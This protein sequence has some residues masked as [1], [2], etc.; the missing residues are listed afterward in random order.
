[1]VKQS[2]GQMF[3]WSNGQ[4]VKWSNGQTV[5]GRHA[6]RGFARSR[7]S[8]LTSWARFD[9]FGFDQFGPFDQPWPVLTCLD[10]FTPAL[11][12]FDRFDHFDQLL[13]V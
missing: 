6:A 1:M 13:L 10:Q 3:K 4:M 9:P 5:K 11:T 7:P 12:S 8:G 2:Y